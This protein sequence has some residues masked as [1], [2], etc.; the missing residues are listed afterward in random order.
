MS[1]TVSTEAPAKA[2]RAASA[3]RPPR[4]R[5]PHKRALLA[6]LGPFLIL[7]ILFYIVPIAY[8]LYQSFFKIERQGAFG[9]PKQVFGGLTQYALVFSNGDFWSSIGR[10]LAFFFASVPLQLGLA[11]VFALLLDSPVLKG[12]KFFRLSFFAPYAVPG[13]IAALMWGFLYAPSLSPF[14]A[15]AERVDFLGP[16]LVLYSIANIVIWVYTGYNMLII[17]SALKAIPEELFEAARVDGAGQFRI[18]WSIKIP[19]VMP[20]IILTGVFSIIG[21]LQLFNEPTVM[22]TLTGSVSN[23]YT[24]NMVVYA[25]S[26]VPNYNLSAAFSVVLALATCLLSF[27]FLKLTQKQAFA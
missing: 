22:R 26:N 12:A 7:F 18:A 24:P 17:Y 27:L 5:V 6:F 13:V 2:G 8:A 25:T 21:T 4:E 14:T 19:I 10:V 9:P 23:S 16:K 1:T 15:L 3:P 20:A 11:L